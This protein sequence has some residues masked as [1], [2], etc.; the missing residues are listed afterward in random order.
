MVRVRLVVERRHLAIAGR[1]VQ[2][3]RLAQGPVG[4]QTQDAHPVR[5]GAS[6]QLGQEPAPQ[7][8]SADGRGH[9]HPL[10]LGGRAGVKLERSAADRLRVQGRDQEQASGPGHLVVGG[11]DAPGRVEAAVEATRQ[12]LDVRSQAVPRVGMPRIALA[13]LD[14]RGSQQ[15]LHLGHRGNEPAALPRAEWIEQTSGGRV[16]QAVKF[17][18]FGLPGGG[19]PGGPEPGVRLAHLDGDQPVPFQRPQQPAQVAGVQV[20][21][22]SQVPDVAAG[23]ADL[24]QQPGLPERPATGQEGV[25]ERADALRDGPVEPPDRLDHDPLHSLTIVR[26]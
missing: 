21:P 23:R 15:P 24:P 22:R 7:A 3:D 2:A 5:G 8:K 9:P 1:Q 16:G 6:L 26:E 13:D 4:L 18:P 11:R 14:R 17:G 10:D 12:F 19:Q 25:V 20:Q